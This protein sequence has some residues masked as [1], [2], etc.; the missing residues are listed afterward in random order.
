MEKLVKLCQAFWDF[1]WANTWWGKIV[2]IPAIILI[3]VPV[4][5]IVEVGGPVLISLRDGWKGLMKVL[6]GDWH[7]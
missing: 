6:F 7:L 2:R 3:C 1:D 5:F 4:V